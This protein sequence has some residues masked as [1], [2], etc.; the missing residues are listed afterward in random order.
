M[1]TILIT[2]DEDVITSFRKILGET[3]N[4][5]FNNFQDCIKKI[6]NGLIPNIIFSEIN[7]GGMPFSNFV[8]ILKNHIHSSNSFIFGL[9]KKITPETQNFAVSL[10]L[11]D[12]LTLPIDPKTLKLKIQFIEDYQYKLLENSGG[13][14][15]EE[16]AKQYRL[17]LLKRVFD[18]ISA[19]IALIILL[20]VFILVAILIR[21]DSQGPIFY[22]SKRVGTG[23]S[24]FNLIKF[25]TMGVNADQQLKGLEHLNEYNNYQLEPINDVEPEII[26]ENYSD[27]ILKCCKCNKIVYNIIE[28]EM[29]DDY[30]I[31]KAC[32]GFTSKSFSDNT[33]YKIK[34][35]PR[36]T[37]LGK[38]LRNTSIDELPQLINV[39]KGDMSLVGNRPLPL[40]EAEKLTTDDLI[41]RFLAPAGL[42]GLW[43]ITKRG[44]SDVSS[45]ERVSL[46]NQYASH[47][48]FLMDFKIILKTFPALIQ[49]ENV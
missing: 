21:I 23:Y 16:E 2:K 31:C 25:R 47:N 26:D 32:S 41:L 34:N 19:S 12:M 5:I 15:E 18:I 13:E 22:F 37:R 20:P 30:F 45:E 4:F 11:T 9:T 40:Y 35:D 49:S 36:I 33:F 48:S 7:L 28:G 46:D 43:Q 17:P 14:E 29:C 44:K 24:I 38:I 6:D 39:L 1:I 10:K 8:T 42:T 3:N 27:Q